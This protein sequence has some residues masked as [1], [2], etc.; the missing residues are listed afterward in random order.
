MAS[1]LKLHEELCEILGSKN[2]YFQPPE[3]IK[4][5]YP[6]IVYSKSRPDLKRANDSIYKYT[7]CYS[8]IYMD[9]N[10]DS[11]IPDKILYH[12]PMCG[13]DRAYTSNN[14]NHNALT[15]YY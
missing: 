1:R 9:T 2:V 4:L 5:N 10:P 7:N 3:N 12:F 15:L 13:F 14:L 8:I 6:C 11:D